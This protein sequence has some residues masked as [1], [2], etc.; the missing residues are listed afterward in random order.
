LVSTAG[1]RQVIPLVTY[2]D[3]AGKKVEYVSTDAK[4]TAREL[5]TAERRK[6]DCMDCHNRPTHAFQ[7]PERAVDEAMTA[8]RIS[9]R[10]PY[11]KR[12]AVAALRASYPD[13]ASASARIPAALVDFYRTKYPAVYQSERATIETA[14]EQVK[15]VYLRNVF[16][17][18][19]VVWGTHPNNIGHEDFLGCFRCHDGKHKSSDGR[20]IRDDCET[21][22]QVL[23]MEE[24]QP[25][26][27]ADLGLK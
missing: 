15:A 27:L 20:V 11:V 4:A 13:R 25:K 22:H 3:D 8:G 6:M 10:L 1:R 19:K 16:P 12:E 2:I 9:T 21:C 26:V 5:A 18:M 7:M 24:E 17:E 23:A 14:A